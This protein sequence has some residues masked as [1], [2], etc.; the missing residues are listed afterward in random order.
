MIATTIRESGWKKTWL[1]QIAEMLYERDQYKAKRR[2]RRLNEIPA[3]SLPRQILLLF[4]TGVFVFELIQSQS[5]SQ[6]ISYYD[7]LVLGGLHD[8]GSRVGCSTVR[9]FAQY[10]ISFLLR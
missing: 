3:Q 1:G 8:V 6:N 4:I 10:F 2:G 7:E 9:I 5:R